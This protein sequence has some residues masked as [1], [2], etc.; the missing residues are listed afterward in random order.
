MRDHGLCLERVHLEK[1]PGRYFERTLEHL[2]D[3]KIIP[4]HGVGLFR[5]QVDHRKAHIDFQF[6]W[7]RGV[8]IQHQ[9]HLIIC[10]KAQFDFLQSRVG[11][12]GKFWPGLIQDRLRQVTFTDLDHPA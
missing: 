9:Q 1:R 6:G 4:G 3:H 12:E 7:E 11:F 8:A 5:A 10:A 2:H